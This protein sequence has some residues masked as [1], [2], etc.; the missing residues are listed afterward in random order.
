[1][2]VSITLKQNAEPGKEFLN[3]RVI[4]VTECAC[5]ENN[6]DL[7]LRL[8]VPA[9][10]TNIFIKSYRNDS[11]EIRLTMNKLLTYGYYSFHLEKIYFPKD[12]GYTETF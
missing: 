6:G 7:Y 8:K 1:M 2:R 12:V 4:E 11:C 5:W 10:G 3:D 9:Y